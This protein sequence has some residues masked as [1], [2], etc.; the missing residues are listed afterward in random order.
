MR[1]IRAGLRL[2][3]IKMY[4]QTRTGEEVGGSVYQPVAALAAQTVSP[5]AYPPAA[6]YASY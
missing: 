1:Q 5:T 6:A 2:A 4:V 3:V